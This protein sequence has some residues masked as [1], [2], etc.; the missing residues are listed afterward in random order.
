M[1]RLGDMLRAMGRYR[2][3]GNRSVRCP[4]YNATILDRCLGQRRLGMRPTARS[5]EGA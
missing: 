2:K 5:F 1:R 3:R 4:T